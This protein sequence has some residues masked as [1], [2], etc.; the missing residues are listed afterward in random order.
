MGDFG[1]QLKNIRITLL[2]VILCA[3][4]CLPANAESPLLDKKEDGTYLVNLEVRFPPG[5]KRFHPRFKRELKKLAELLKKTTDIG[6]VTIVGHTD[7][8]GNQGVNLRLSKVRA[9]YVR[10]Y[11]I[12]SGLPKER[13]EIVARAGGEPRYPN[14]KRWG[15]RKNRR[16]EFEIPGAPGESPPEAEEPPKEIPATEEEAPE[17]SQ[18]LESEEMAPAAESEPESELEPEPEPESEFPDEL[19][20]R[21]NPQ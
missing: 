3:T 20:P 13:L 5:A 16:V 2:S 17:E 9:N 21:H 4:L 6:K 19:P 7:N 1:R 12:R 11:L 10:D 8:Q 18:P 14:D 15:Q